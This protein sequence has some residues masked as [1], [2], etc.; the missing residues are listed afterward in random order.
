MTATVTAADDI[1]DALAHLVCTTDTKDYGPGGGLHQLPPKFFDGFDF[2]NEGE[3]FVLVGESA[4]D[5]PVWPLDV[6][7][8]VHNAPQGE[9]MFTRIRTLPIKDWRGRIKTVFPRMLEYNVSLCN[10]NGGRM[11]GKFAFGAVKGRLIRADGYNNGL[12]ISGSSI[13][14]SFPYGA[15]RLS[16][17]D[18]PI[19]HNIAAASGGFALRK[20]YN[21]SVLLGEGD[22][23]RARF[24]T[25][26]TGVRE[27]FRLRDIP[28]GDRRRKALIHWVR[29]HWRKSREP[30]PSDLTWVT[31]HLRGKQDFVWNGLRGRI[32]PGELAAAEGTFR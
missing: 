27:S 7:W 17:E 2:L 24:T 16:A 31:G 18:D 15:A 25:D 28:P 29:E 12:S 32:E 4:G 11:S 14:L 30:N 22:G 19:L 21:W 6:T 23:P 1:I 9:W 20:R 10:V 3:D 13:G 26:L 8:A 5:Q